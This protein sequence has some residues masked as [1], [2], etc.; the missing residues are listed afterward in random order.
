MKLGFLTACLPR[1]SLYELVPWA[2]AEGF[3]ALELAAWPE[4]SERDYLAHHVPA[5][6]FDLRSSRLRAMAASLFCMRYRVGI[7]SVF[8]GCLYVARP[9]V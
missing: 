3:G 4:D 5:A 2:A 6:T 9:R 8:G 1:V 7:T